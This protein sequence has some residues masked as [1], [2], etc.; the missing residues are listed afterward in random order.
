MACSPA[1]LIWVA[2][3]SRNC[4]PRGL[5]AAAAL[6]N[7]TVYIC[8]APNVQLLLYV[9]LQWRPLGVRGRGRAGVPHQLQGRL[10]GKRDAHSNV[11]PSIGCCAACCLGMRIRARRTATLLLRLPSTPVTHASGCNPIATQLDAMGDQTK[12]S[13]H[14]VHCRAPAPTS[15][16]FALRPLKVVPAHSTAPAASSP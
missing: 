16:L 5:P 4:A 2:T 3:A 11:H 12:S 9:Q 15:C 13:R 14:P 8:P 6:L 7:S 1:R 10:G